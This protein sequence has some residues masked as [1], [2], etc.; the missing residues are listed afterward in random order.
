MEINDDTF[1][2]SIR[3]ILKLLNELLK[4]MKAKN[5]LNGETIYDNQDLC[6]MLKLSK[7]SLQRLRSLGMLP[8]IQIG[9]KTFYLESDILNYIQT[10]IENKRTLNNNDTEESP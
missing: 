3:Q 2:D 8:Y 5:R 9:Q 6:V 10:Q 4:L 1:D 7:R